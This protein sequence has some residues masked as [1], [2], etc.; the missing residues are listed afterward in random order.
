[1]DQ[2]M[3]KI[4][5][6]KSNLRVTRIG[7]GGIPIQRPGEAESIRVL[8]A[9]LNAGINW[10]DTAFGY[11]SSEERIGKAIADIPRDQ[12]L[13][14]TKGP[15]RDPETLK[16]QIESS[17]RRLKVDTLDLYQ[18]HIVPD[19]ETWL[20]MQDNGSF[21]L[22]RDLRKQGVIRHIG[23]SAHS[24]EAAR[25]V[26]EHPEIE[27][28][29]FPFNFIVEKEGGEIFDLCRRGDVGFIAM[30]PFA[31]GELNDAKAA[32]R[33]LLQFPG[34]VTDPGFETRQEVEE[35]TALAKEN[36]PLSAADR[37]TISRLRR[38]LGTRFCRRCGYCSPCPQGVKIVPLMT[39]KSFIK[40]CPPASLASGWPPEALASLEQCNECG[41][42]EA[43]CPYELPIREQI[44][45]GAEA[46]RQLL[47]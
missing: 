26:L 3:K 15:G 43:R 42:C 10:I 9:A 4:R 34:L 33:F 28:F 46:L 5:L 17:L 7:F 30:K 22:V 31:G 1:M 40:R 20:R 19:R 45:E 21:E 13:L 8:R 24:R 35:V 12:V 25:A 27:V 36:A 44:R 38:E 41:E 11:G 37:E 16:R 2:I 29:Q 39:M 18:F 6:G 47:R 32:I 14:F 23:A